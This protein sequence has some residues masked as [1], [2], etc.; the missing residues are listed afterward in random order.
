MRNNWFSTL[1]S[2]L[3]GTQL[4]SIPLAFALSVTFVYAQENVIELTNSNVLAMVRD[5]LPTEAIVKKIQSSRC[6]FDTFPTVISELRQRGVP[7]EVLIA[8]VAAPVGRPT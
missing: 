4:Y 5:K 3:P 1:R 7:E 8:M 6:H 2:F